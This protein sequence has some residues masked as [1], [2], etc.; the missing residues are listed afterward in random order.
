[1]GT[2]RGLERDRG[3]TVRAFLSA[4]RM[5]GLFFAPQP[6]DGP[7][8]QK[9]RQGDDDEADNRVDKEAVVDAYGAGSLGVGQMCVRPRLRALPEDDKK[10]GEVHPSQEQ[11]DGGHQ[12]VIH[13]TLDDRTE[14]TADDNSD[15]HINDVAP[16]RELFE[17]PQ[18]RTSF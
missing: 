13:E 1:M 10:V 17:L 15:R 6:V 5:E 14:G 9:D 18:Y 4:W 7:D 11:A 12:D 16:H 8:E 3:K 2:A